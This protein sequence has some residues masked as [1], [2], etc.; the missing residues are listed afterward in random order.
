M[1]MQCPV[2]LSFI[3]RSSQ[4]QHYSNMSGRPYEPDVCPWPRPPCCLSV[5]K[6]QYCQ[7]DELI[8]ALMPL[9]RVNT[10]IVLTYWAGFESTKLHV[11]ASSAYQGTGGGV[12]V[13]RSRDLSCRIDPE[14]S[15]TMMTDSTSRSIIHRLRRLDHVTRYGQWRHHHVTWSEP[16]RNKACPVTRT[17]DDVTWPDKTCPPNLIRYY[18][19]YL[20]T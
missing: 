6:S 17:N 15:I 20:P 19:Y 3:T 14:G 16:W 11:S 4:Y 8:T 10:M 18:A 12:A 13:A 9:P 2:T 7:R 5:T 1:C